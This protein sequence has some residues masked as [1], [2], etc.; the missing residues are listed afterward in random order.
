MLQPRILCILRIGTESAFILAN[1]KWRVNLPGG[2]F[3]AGR[4]IKG[5]YEMPFL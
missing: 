1:A 4:K 5:L 2:G 3:C